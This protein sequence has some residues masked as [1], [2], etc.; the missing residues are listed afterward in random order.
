M[1]IHAYTY[2][3]AY[4]HTV[5]HNFVHALEYCNIHVDDYN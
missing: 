5:L 3:I 4:K 2:T 1:H